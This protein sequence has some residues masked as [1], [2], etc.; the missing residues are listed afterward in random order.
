MSNLKPGDRA[1]VVGCSMPN[2]RPWNGRIVNID[3]AVWWDGYAHG[4]RYIGW[5]YI[6]SCELGKEFFCA[7]LLIRLPPDDEAKRLFRE[8]QRPREVN[9]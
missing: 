8:T 9:A 5:A 3:E 1:L 4:P 2:T 7:N 6:I